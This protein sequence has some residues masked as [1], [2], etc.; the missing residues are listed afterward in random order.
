M[1]RR[2]PVLPRRA[3]SLTRPSGP[4][5]LSTVPLP[6]STASSSRN[7]ILELDAR[8][9]G[10]E[11]RKRG[12]VNMLSS[13]QRDGGMDRDTII[14]L[15]YSLGS[16]HEV[17][18]YLRIFTSSSKVS[19][20][21]V[22]PEAKFA[23]LKIGGAILSN[24]LD[25]L[26]LSLSFLNRLGLYPVV[27]HGAGPQLNDI[28]ESEGVI[29][30]YEDG[31]RITDARTLQ[32]ARRVFLQE[33]LK[34]T[35]ALE[36]LG[37]RARPIPTGV[38]TADYLDKAKYGLVG[39]I[40]R[41]DKAPIEAAIKAGC[42]PI[43][44]SLAENAEGQ[45]LNVNADVA[46]GELAKVLEPMKIV[47][48]NEKGGLFHG[49]TGKKISLI[50]LDEEYDSLMKESWV[51]F[52]TK[53]KLREIKELL[54]TLPRTS[55]V[56]IIST[57]MLQKE[58]FTDEGAGT[59]I[60]R[61]YK[62]Y[63]LPSVEAVGST[64]LRQVFSERDPDVLA[65]RKSVAEIFSELKD[66]QH[67]IY[68]DEPFDV[69]A[70]V[71]H[72]EG[73]TPVM[74]KFLPSRN[75]ILNKIVDNVF[76]AI[77]KDHKRLFWTA[78][79]DD[80]NRA[81]H[82]ERADGCFTR[83]GRS[84]FWYGVPNVKDVEHIIE[85]FEQN[86]RIE[87][88]F[89][90]VGPSVP[91][92]RLSTPASGTRPYSTSARLFSTFR[93]SFSTQSIAPS[94]DITSR[95]G[96]ATAVPR[97]KVALIGARGYTGQNL[98]SIINSHPH[99]DLS[100]VSS[101]ELAGLPLKE[102]TKS[103]VTYSNLSPETVGKMAENNE[104][105]AWVMALPNGICKPFVDAIDS[106]VGKG[107]KGVIVDLSA[108]YRFE[109]DWT[110]GLPELYGREKVRNSKRVS[111]P[112]CYATNTQLLVAPLL[113]VL[114]KNQAP[115]VFGISGY[116]GAGTR[117]GEKDEE[118]R[119]KTVPKISPEDLA[120]G[121]KPYSLT[122]HIHE[123]EASTHL[124]TLLFPSSSSS[125]SPSP[126]SLSSTLTNLTS[127]SPS[128]IL[129]NLK[130]SSSS[131]SSKSSQEIQPKEGFSLN[132]IPTVGPWFSGILSILN[133]PLEK[134]MR[135]SE[136]QDLYFEKYD[137][138]GLLRVGKEVPDVIRDVEGKHGWRMGGIQV[139]SS[140]KRVVVVGALDNLL[141]GAATQCMQ[142]LNLALGYDELD[143][144]PL[145]KI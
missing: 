36:R 136:I 134:S 55:S 123:R 105:D 91:P 90:P 19:T 110:Y 99:L 12:L 45:I 135:A 93:P 23:V 71:S 79:A 13:A 46:A 72:P 52:G 111:N 41:V 44:T 101:R 77:R 1:L 68:G 113:S 94:T 22:L 11:I 2:V 85:G 7:V 128:T 127:S 100:H 59:L 106:A 73:E 65:G 130:S 131:F 54:D 117:S 143:G 21:G 24:E 83:A 75:G 3:I 116:S 126:S 33:N 86:G 118:G 37:T 112:G 140:G 142:N 69:V 80:E 125:S 10:N 132:F 60:R 67:T 115:T 29:P 139:H 88:V 6:I 57:D 15:L 121:V 137:K 17:E 141:K 18:R 108:D 98:I 96:Y 4:R 144:I 42:L 14:R 92:H 56:A 87:R 34:L 104:V 76:E 31:I 26:A 32:V 39:K 58:L 81:W 47:Y 82:F 25:D 61:G 66:G 62:L 74:T 114:D 38:F 50:N 70:V 5:F 84:L 49:V 16:R 78:R 40:T 51:K 124:S 107:G 119:P 30:D 64:Q 9:V 48:L 133:A 97:K 43:L 109:K 53:L 28:L 103:P 89:L 102:Y 122:D 35:T 20:G 8:K 95:R 138:E 120:G 129:S 63:K 27:L 145:D